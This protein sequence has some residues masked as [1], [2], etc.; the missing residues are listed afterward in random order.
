MYDS[1]MR[2][3]AKDLPLD[4]KD[5][6]KLELAISHSRTFP[7]LQGGRYRAVKGNNRKIGHR[8]KLNISQTQSKLSIRFDGIPFDTLCC[9]AAVV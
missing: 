4:P 5:L 9:Y 1:T 6:R 3:A 2:L 7:N 8:P